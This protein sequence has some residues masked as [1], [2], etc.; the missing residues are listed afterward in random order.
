MAPSG[1]PVLPCAPSDALE[2]VVAPTTSSGDASQ[3]PA[4]TTSKAKW[5]SGCDFQHVA[6]GVGSM[7][8]SFAAAFRKA[9]AMD[10]HITKY[11]G[12]M[13]Q[14]L[15]P[16]FQTMTDGLHRLA[17]EEKAEDAKAEKDRLQNAQAKRRKTDADVKYRARRVTIR[18]ASMAN[19]CYWLSCAEV[20]VHILTNGDCLQSHCHQRLFTRQLQWALQECKR[21]LNKESG[22]DTSK[23][24]DRCGT[25]LLEI[26]MRIPHSGDA[27]QLTVDAN[28]QLPTL[29]DND[30]LMDGVSQPVHGPYSD[31]H[32][33]DGDALPN[34][35]QSTGDPDVVNMFS[36]TNTANASDDYAHRGPT[37]HSMPFYVYIA[38]VRPHARGKPLPR[39]GQVIEFE[40]HYSKFKSYVQVVRLT[41]INIPTIDGFQCPT[42]QQD[43]EQNSLLMQILCFPWRCT[44]PHKCDCTSKFTQLLSNG[45]CQ[46]PNKSE[47]RSTR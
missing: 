26:Q 29:S 31:H 9:F 27:P 30:V 16:L 14:S 6:A 42:W 2:L 40:Q 41:D 17:E 13:M 3:L 35:T 1:L 18:L 38:H 34:T 47:C 39:H 11:Q 15:T 32:A 21:H 44:D 33:V 12:K 37:L 5:L 19:R 45:D 28:A 24:Q 25:G 46:G 8:E 23:K 22:S 20:A 36:R 10:F 4:A 43:P 7:L